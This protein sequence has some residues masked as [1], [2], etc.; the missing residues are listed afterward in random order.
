MSNGLSLFTLPHP[1]LFPVGKI[2]ISNSGGL[3]IHSPLCLT[4]WALV[5]VLF[6]KIL[7]DSD[8]DDVVG[9]RRGVKSEVLSDTWPVLGQIFFHPYENEGHLENLPF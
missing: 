8:Q 1:V 4:A 5:I 7:N 3:F 9:H 6:T 2:P